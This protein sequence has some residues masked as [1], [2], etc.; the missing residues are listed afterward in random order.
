MNRLAVERGYG[1]R[2]GLVWSGLV[3]WFREFG[4]CA[5]LGLRD[6][7]RKR[8]GDESIIRVGTWVRK[9]HTHKS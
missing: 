7:Q 3:D 8:E 5:F 4:G 9:C 1:R 6:D 2:C